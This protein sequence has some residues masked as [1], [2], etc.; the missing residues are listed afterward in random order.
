MLILDELQGMGFVKNVSALEKFLKIPKQTLYQVL[1]GSRGIPL[2]H[3]DKVL[4]FFTGRYDVNPEF[5]HNQLVEIFKSDP[6]E[7][8]EDA[9][10]YVTSSKQISRN[11]LTTGDMREYEMLRSENERLKKTIQ[12]KETVIRNM[13]LQIKSMQRLIDQFSA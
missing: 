5:F 2:V 12:D 9:E 3:R 1:N 7:V 8:R 11:R 13:Q 4:K 6:P 10:K